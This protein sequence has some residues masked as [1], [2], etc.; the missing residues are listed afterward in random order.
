MDRNERDAHAAL[1]ASSHGAEVWSG[2]ADTA[3]DDPVDHGYDESRPRFKRRYAWSALALILAP[4]VAVGVVA[5]L[6]VRCSP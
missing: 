1:I 6:A 3:T 4:W 5:T 2:W